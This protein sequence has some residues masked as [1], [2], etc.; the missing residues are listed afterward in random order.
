MKKDLNNLE[1][2]KGNN[3]FK[4]PEGYFESVTSQIMSKL[5]EKTYQQPKKV[6]VMERVRPWLYMAAVFAGLGLFFKVI[7][8]FGGSSDSLANTDSV[9]IQSSVP[10]NTLAV[11]Q[12]EAEEDYLEYLESQYAGYILAEEMEIYE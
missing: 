4:V 10:L 7:I 9:N 8:G 3:P 12:T 1:H 5:P 6:T 2:L 11:Y